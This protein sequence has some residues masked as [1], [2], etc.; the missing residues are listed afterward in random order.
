[1]SKQQKP[2]TM[3]ASSQTLDAA[4]RAVLERSRSGAAGVHLDQHSPKRRGALTTTRSLTRSAVRR[5]A[6]RDQESR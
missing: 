2:A 3:S 1:M 4:V 6:L 5:Q